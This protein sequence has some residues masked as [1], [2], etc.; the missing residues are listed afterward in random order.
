MMIRRRR[1]KD[2]DYIGPARGWAK[3]FHRLF[4]FIT[5]PIRKP[6]WSLLIVLVMFLA[7]TFKGVKPAEVHLWYWNLLKKSGNQMADKAKEA[8]AEIPVEKIGN[9]LQ[10]QV[11]QQ[12]DIEMT[13]PKSSSRKIFVK[14]DSAPIA[15]NVS[16]DKINGRLLNAKNTNA[17]EIE[18]IP[19]IIKKGRAALKY[20]DKPETIL[21]K[22]YVINANELKVG[23]VELFLYGVYVNPKTEVGRK[24]KQF[25]IETVENRNMSCQIIA[26]TYQNI[27]TAN[28]MIDDI[29]IND[30]L[31]ENG[32][33][34]K[35]VLE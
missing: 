15:K 23:D 25:L 32:Y 1:R 35:V 20:L 22:A 26:Y 27:A 10:G 24:A 21:G 14:T 30:K 12:F 17:T 4:L 11:L 7:P 8:V 31:V 3:F 6:W 28:C 13:T 5:F 9:V 33:S 18:N 2:D 19:V 29:N 16:F 34:K